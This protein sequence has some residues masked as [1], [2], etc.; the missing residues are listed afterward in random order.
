MVD[1]R[2]GEDETPIVVAMYQTFVH[3]M[4]MEQCHKLEFANGCGSF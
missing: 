1:D 3:E 4:C 2:P